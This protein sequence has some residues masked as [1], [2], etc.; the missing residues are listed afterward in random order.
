MFVKVPSELG[1]YLKY[2]TNDWQEARAAMEEGY[3]VVNLQ[4]TGYWT[5]IGHYLLL[6]K[7]TEDG[8]VQVRDSNLLNY[9]KLKEHQED[10]FGWETLYPNDQTY[11][12]YEKKLTH[13][14]ACSRCGQPEGEGIC[15]GIF[16]EEYFCE[17][18]A[19]AT[20]RR[21]NFLTIME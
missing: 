21:D 12:V 17:K 5:T 7:L 9:H 6:E 19:V 2:S 1:F 8:R 13:I 16:T 18:C 15:I 10:A 11:W 3:I 20:S 4:G 14:P